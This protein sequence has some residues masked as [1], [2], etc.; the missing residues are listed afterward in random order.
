VKILP[1]NGSIRFEI[2]FVEGRILYSTKGKVAGDEE[3]RIESKFEFVVR[4][5]A[6][7]AD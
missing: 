4:V 7:V 2:G 1:Q 5:D 3:E 6:V